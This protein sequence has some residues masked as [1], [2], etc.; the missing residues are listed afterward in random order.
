MGCFIFGFPSFQTV[1]AKGNGAV[2]QEVNSA[3]LGISSTAGRRQNWSRS[4]AG[5]D[6]TCRMFEWFQEDLSACFFLLV[7]SIIV[8]T[9]VVV[10]S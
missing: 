5:M 3:A 2:V 7:F 6:R 9:T 10:S 8:S 1:K 4:E